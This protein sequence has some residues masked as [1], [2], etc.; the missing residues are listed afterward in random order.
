MIDR[1]DEQGKTAGQEQQ[2]NKSN[3]SVPIRKDFGSS[4]AGS[5][6]FLPQL[7]RLAALSRRIPGGST[8]G[9]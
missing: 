4:F 5:S 8:A 6:A 1:V 9:S 3:A 7:Q 2:I